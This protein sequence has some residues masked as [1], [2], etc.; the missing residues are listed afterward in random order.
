MS[1]SRRITSQSRRRRP[2]GGGGRAFTLVESVIAVLIVSTVLVAALRTFGSLARARLIQT[3]RTLAYGLADDLLAE[4]MQCRFTEPGGGTTL[5]PD[6]GEMRGTYD[7]VDDYDGLSQTPPQL[8]DGTALTEFTGWTRSVSVTFVNPDAPDVAA[9]PA[10]S[11]L[12]RIIV[13]VKSPRGVSVTLR[14]LR[15]SDG[16][17]EQAPTATT[18]YLTGVGVSARV[19]TF[20][21]SAYGAARPLNVQQSQ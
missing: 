9:S 8:R 11:Q 17:Y 4:V 1:T 10:D 6:A 16:P 21:K 13:T 14:G 7:D 5:G 3:D 18:N 20:G 12:K 19:G 2:R 15:S